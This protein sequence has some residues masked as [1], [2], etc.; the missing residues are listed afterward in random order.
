MTNRYSLQSTI[1]DCWWRHGAVVEELAALQVAWV[2]AFFVDPAE[3]G[4]SQ[5][6]WHESLDRCLERIERRWQLGGCRAG[7]VAS[8]LANREM[9]TG[10]EVEDAMK[11]TIPP[12]E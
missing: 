10:A 3:A 4:S 7:H 6:H 8:S 11:P 1:R 12:A 2:G 5:A 9:P